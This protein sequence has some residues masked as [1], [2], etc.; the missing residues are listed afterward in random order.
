M[1]NGRLMAGGIAQIL[2]QVLTGFTLVSH[3]TGWPDVSVWVIAYLGAA[4]LVP[5]R[6][7]GSLKDRAAGN[8]GAG[9]VIAGFLWWEVLINGLG[10][11]IGGGGSGL[12]VEALLMLAATVLF[13]VAGAMFWLLREE[14]AGR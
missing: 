7:N 14:G 10:G 11:L 12:G 1:G 4:I 2:G 5:F 9:V 6:H 3:V 8:F 13:T